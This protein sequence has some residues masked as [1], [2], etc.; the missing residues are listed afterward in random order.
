MNDRYAIAAQTIKDTVSA[1]EVAVSI[2]LKM[3]N[4][5]CQCP[6]HGGQNYNC[7][8]YKGTRGWFCH[9]CHAGG[10]VISFVQRYYSIGFKDSIRWV[11]D[12]FHLGLDID[13]SISPEQQRQ[14]EMALKRRKNAIEFQEWKDRMQFNL[15]LL[16]DDFVRL[17]EDI[18]DERRPRTYGEWDPG[19]CTAVMLLPDARRFADDCMMDC[20]K[21][22]KE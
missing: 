10:D 1:Y 7:V 21:E 13:S 18:R 9:Q 20:M 16:A 11:N 17:L 6:I 15:A 5:R 19:F 12:T 2:G 8:M 4:G 22:R 14:A 3:R